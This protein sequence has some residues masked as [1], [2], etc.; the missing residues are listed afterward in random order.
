MYPKSAHIDT[1]RKRLILFLR[2]QKTIC[3]TV[4]KTQYCLWWHNIYVCNKNSINFQVACLI[5]QNSVGRKKKKKKS[6]PCKACHLKFDIIWNCSIAWNILLSIQMTL[7]VLSQ[8]SEQSESSDGLRKYKVF[9]NSTLPDIMV[10]G[11]II[12]ARFPQLLLP[13]HLI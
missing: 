10:R 3:F 12:L 6:L 5:M 11:C 4:A 8:V 2:P 13:K 9:T 1:N 7:N